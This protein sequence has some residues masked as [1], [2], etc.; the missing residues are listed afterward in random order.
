MS[1]EAYF[2]ELLGVETQE[3]DGG[4]Y[5]YKV[6]GVEFNVVAV[7]LRPERRRFLAYRDGFN[8]MMD[9]AA[10]LGCKSIIATV[11]VGSKSVSVALTTM[12]KAGFEI[13]KAEAGVITLQRNI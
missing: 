3:I 6:E 13:I 5:S 4:F 1:Y 8:H 10:E 9:K 2:K 11:T 7:Y 12:L